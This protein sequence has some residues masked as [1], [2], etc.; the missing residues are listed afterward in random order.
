M[1]KSIYIIKNDINSKV[2][3]GQAICVQKRFN[4]HCCGYNNR[5]NSIITNAIKKYGKEHFWVEIL[6]KDIENFNEQE[7]YWIE[8]YNSI[9]PNGYNISP[10]GE[11]G[12]VGLT[13]PQS[14]LT[15]DKL[16]QIIEVLQKSDKPY[17]IIAKEFSVSTS[18][19]SRINRGV[20]YAQEGFS[21]PI[22]K[23]PQKKAENNIEEIWQLLSYSYRSYE[24]IGIQYNLSSSTIGKINRGEAYYN[25]ELDYP[26]RK[27]RVT[28]QTKYSYE[29]VTDII[30]LLLYT[31]L[32][33]RAIG[34]LYN[35]P[36][37]NI[38]KEIKNGTNK[39]YRRNEYIYPLRPNHFQKPV[40]TISVKESTVIIDT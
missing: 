12:C 17:T 15:K 32:S 36:N 31:N 39:L 38:I 4:E 2:Y 28:S 16:F 13:S 26:I 33:L 3:I 27:S 9:R 34:R 6:E 40:S 20:S 23:N 11:S 18:L 25:P 22:R 8:Y 37:I 30:N 35:D 21:Y 10:G 1:K 19:V 14:I 24:S 29:E 7:Q 5:P